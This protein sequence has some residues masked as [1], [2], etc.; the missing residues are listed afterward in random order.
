MNIDL[1]A[2]PTHFIP[3]FRGLFGDKRLAMRTQKL[4]S[5]LSLHPSSSIRRLSASRSEQKAYYRLLLNHKV[6]ESILI[7]ELTSRVS[8]FGFRA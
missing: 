5:R 1:S 6:S 4:F 7:Q 2:H 3:D 8:G